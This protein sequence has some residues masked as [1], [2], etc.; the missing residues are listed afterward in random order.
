MSWAWLCLPIIPATEEAEMGFHHDG[1]ASL[2]LLTSGDPPT[3]VSQSARI[4]GMSHHVWPIEFHSFSQAG[5]KWYNLGSLQPLPR[6][7]NR[8]GFSP[9]YPGWSQTPDPRRFTVLASQSARFTA[10]SHR[11]QPKLHFLMR[12]AAIPFCKGQFC[13]CCPGWSAM[14]R[15][16]L[17]ATSTSWVE[18]IL[19]PQPPELECNGM[20]SAHCNLHLLGSSDSPSSAFRVAGIT[21]MRHHTQ[22]ID[23]I[24]PFG[25]AG[26][27]LPTS[28]DSFALALQ[29]AEITDSLA[30][31]PRLECSGAISAHCNLCLPGSSNSPASESGVAGITSAHRLAW[32][33]FVFLLEIGFLHVGQAGLKLL[34][35]GDL[36]TSTPQCTRI[37]GRQ[38]LTLSPGMECSDTITAHGSLNLLNSSNLST[39]SPLVTWFMPVILAL[40]EAEVGGSRGQEFETSLANMGLTLSP[41]LECSGAIIAHGSLNLS[42]SSDPPTSSSH[43]AVAEGTC[44]HT[45]LISVY[46]GE[47]G[48]RHVAQANLELLSSR[49]PQASTSQR[50]KITGM[51]HCIRPT[52]SLGFHHDG[53]AGLE[54]LTSGDPPT[55]ASQRSLSSRLVCSRTI[56][57]HYSL[58]VLA[59]SNPPTLTS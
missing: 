56:I 41:R 47:M 43:V 25:Q 21:G 24:S 36:P 19:L 38:G 32:L 11:T 31:S 10:V 33:I 13:S 7:F 39:L 52:Y 30:L 54:L 2:E 34:T 28:G 3:L 44:Q 20:I 22:L 48:F 16:Q 51:S 58:Q 8:D 29:S 4:T 50:A 6:E 42:G 5:I 14:V 12:A 1:Q 23:G 59:S 26:L 45:C 53:Q 37:T 9:C 55:S 17:T 57:A 40:W 49:D 35:S 18:V 15:S 27:E 46:F